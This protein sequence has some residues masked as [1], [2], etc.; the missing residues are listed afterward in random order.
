MKPKNIILR[1]RLAYVES[2]LTTEPLPSR[3]SPRLQEERQRRLTQ[4]KI[5]IQRSLN[6]IIYPILTLPVEITTEIF[7]HC[8]PD[9]AVS[10]SGT[11]A[12]MLLGRICRQWSN[13]ACS[14]PRLWAHFVAHF[15]QGPRFEPLLREWLRRARTAPLSLA[16]LLPFNRSAHSTSLATLTLP[17]TDHWAQITSFRGSSLTPVECLDLLARAPNLTHCELNKNATNSYLLPSPSPSTSRLLHARLQHLELANSLLLV[18]DLLTAPALHSLKITGRLQP[19]AATVLPSFLERAL[20]LRTFD[21]SSFD[22]AGTGILCDVLR[23]IPLLN[24]LRLAL[25]STASFE[26]LHLLN[27]S[28]AFLPRIQNITLSS[29]YGLH[30]TDSS[31]QTFAD[32]VTSRWEA[33]STATQ[34]L[35][36]KIL[37]D[38]VYDR[39]LDDRISACVSRLEEQGMRIYVGSERHR[40]K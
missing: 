15:W 23:A 9:Y 29:F 35:E 3:H 28:P 14:T 26:L 12:P 33:R 25:H 8:L 24:S 17:F 16:L 4:E 39:I 34:L 19:V 31:I 21:A 37:M 30:W 11:V 32:A 6:S 13:I 2:Q 18:L 5:T 27:E 20:K 22:V 36:F 1:R 10:P 40:I 38:P 7:L